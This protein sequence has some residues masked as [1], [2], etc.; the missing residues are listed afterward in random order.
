[1]SG[2]SHGFFAFFR[3]YIL[4][5]GFLDGACGFLLAVTNAE[6]TY[7]RYMKAWAARRHRDVQQVRLVRGGETPL[8]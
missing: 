3:T 7:Y 8:Q 4:Q 6:G 5:L 2:I 1:M